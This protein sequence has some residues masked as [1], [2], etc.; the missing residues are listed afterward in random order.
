MCYGYI[1]HAPAGHQSAVACRY[2]DPDALAAMSKASKF[3]MVDPTMGDDV[4]RH[5]AQEVNDR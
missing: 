3:Q 2:L 5:M 1:S 4:Y